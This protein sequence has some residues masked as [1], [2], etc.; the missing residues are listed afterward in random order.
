MSAILNSLVT[1]ILPADT[2]DTRV[3]GAREINFV[4]TDEILVI[5]TNLNDARNVNYVHTDKILEVAGPS[6]S[7]LNFPSDTNYEIP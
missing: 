5:L 7:I 6:P 4:N 2:T 3:L 1:S